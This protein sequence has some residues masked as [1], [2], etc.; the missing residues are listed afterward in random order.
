LKIGVN[1]R[2]LLQPGSGV[3]NYLA[4]LYRKCQEI[5]QR[6]QYVFFQPNASQTIG[7]TEVEPAASGLA[8]GAMFDSW[9]VDRLIQRTQPTVFHGPA[10]ILPLR[11]R[12]RV[13]YVV[14]IHDLTTVVLPKQYRWSHRWYYG[15]Q[16]PRSLRVADAIM[17]DSH[18]TKRDI[19]RFYKIPE[20]RVH[21]VHLGVP[22]HYL[23][24]A[25]QD[26]KR[27]F[28]GKYFFSLTTHP[29]RKNILGALRAFARF[30][31]ETQLVFVI[32]G[33]M[34]EA[35]KGVMLTLARELGIEDRVVLFGYASDEQLRSLYQHAE[36]L[37]YPS[38]YE[39]FGFPVVE[40]MACGC[41][42]VASNASSLPELMPNDDW[43]FD[44]H[45]I[46]QMATMMKR[47]LSLPPEKRQALIASN[48]DFARKF[49]W[50]KAARQTLDLFES[51][52]K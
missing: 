28:P 48:R 40:A 23:R 32:A 50:E 14:T 27:L 36:F 39:G 29:T 35:Q 3:P 15:F 43:L 5:D 19:L 2:F 37:I 6:N 24:S 46:E 41:P 1:S 51:L 42:V 31:A 12:K 11:R 30:A 22:E 49:T 21:V 20:D 7:P 18:N 38:F 33:L 26:L 45:N 13:K 25:S 17:A 44:P 34:D 9:L 16:V 47:V 4:N 52:T 8:G 10:H